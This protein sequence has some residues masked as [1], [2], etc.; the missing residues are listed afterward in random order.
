MYINF[1]SDI[2]LERSQN[3]PF[4][5]GTVS[6]YLIISTNEREILLYFNRTCEIVSYR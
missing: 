6:D 1:N 4:N 5:L 3:S 2:S